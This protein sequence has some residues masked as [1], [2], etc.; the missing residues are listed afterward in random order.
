[1]IHHPPDHT[2]TVVFAES[3]KVVFFLVIDSLGEGKVDSLIKDSCSV[4]S[5]NFCWHHTR[6]P[7][8]MILI[9]M[10]EVLV[11]DNMLLIADYAKASWQMFLSIASQSSKNGVNL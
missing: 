7:I 9:I 1:M 4:A 2:L 11:N 3:K 8:R 6:S 5:D 10:Q